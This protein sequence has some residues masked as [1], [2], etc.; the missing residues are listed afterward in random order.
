M[1]RSG[2]NS[3]ANRRISLISWTNARNLTMNVVFYSLVTGV[4][5]NLCNNLYFVHSINI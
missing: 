2:L 3:S 4:A 1:N 5:D